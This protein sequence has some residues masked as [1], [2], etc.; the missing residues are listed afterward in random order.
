MTVETL[1][2]LPTELGTARHVGTFENGSPEWHGQRATGIGGSDVGILCGLS[3]WESPYTWVAKRLG[4][5]PS[6]METSEPMEWGTRLEAPILDAFIEKN[7]HLTVYRDAGSWHHAD[8]PW[9]LANPDALYQDANGT[10]GIVEVKTARYEDDWDEKNNTIPASYRAQV[11][12]YLQTFGF[13][14]AYVVVLFSGSKFRVFE[15]TTNDFEADTNLAVAMDFK[16]YLDDQE[17]PP[18]S[19]P[20]NS[21]YETVRYQHPLID[22]SEVELGEVGRTYFEAVRAQAEATEELDRSKSEVI[23]AMGNAKRGLLDGNWTVTRQAR[24]GGTPY[25]VNKRG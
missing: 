24:A 11:L 20:F 12:W 1:A 25:L 4:K 22:D 19:A 6:N 15:V 14:H 18:F 9:Q 16:K 3:K 2:T 13:Q 17:L 21:T 8:R 5:I 23:A 10:W 7:P